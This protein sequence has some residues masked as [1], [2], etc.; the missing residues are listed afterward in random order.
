MA[1]KRKTAS[2]VTN[3]AR[4][5]A[6]RPD[7][8]DRVRELTYQAIRDRRLSPAGV[9]ALVHQVLEGASEAVDSAIPSSKRSVLRQVFDGLGDAFQT[10]GAAGVHAAESAAERGRT[11]ARRTLPSTTKR[12]RSANDEFLAAVSS[13]A[14]HT[15]SELGDELDSLVKRARRAGSKAGDSARDAAHAADGRLL[16]LTGEAARAGVSVARRA[17]GGLAM[18]AGGMFEG[19]RDAITSRAKERPAAPAKRP[20]VKGRTK[21]RSS[22]KTRTAKRPARRS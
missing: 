4:T 19:L 16:E 7:T 3:Q 11:V 13:F 6:S 10:V 14:K 12:V 8:R 9:S 2:K 20:A 5:A 1:T 22:A 18:A 17:A 15:K 21:S